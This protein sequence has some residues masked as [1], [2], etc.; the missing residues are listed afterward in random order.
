MMSVQPTIQRRKQ[1]KK[2]PMLTSVDRNILFVI[3]HKWLTHLIGDY[4][5]TE[6]RR[7]LNTSSAA[8]MLAHIEKIKAKTVEVDPE[9]YPWSYSPWVLAHDHLMV[10]IH[11]RSEHLEAHPDYIA[12]T[13]LGF[14]IARYAKGVGG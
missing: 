5:P 11:G 14:A 13:A 12:M 9:D 3:R 1:P 7:G 6:L 10:C 2:D 4:L 8:N